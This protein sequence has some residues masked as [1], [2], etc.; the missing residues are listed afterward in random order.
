M[1][2]QTENIPEGK[3]L[4]CIIPM[5]VSK[6]RLDAIDRLAY[7]NLDTTM[8]QDIGFLVV[9]DG[10]APEDAAR[11]RARCAELGLGYVRVDSELR[12]F[13][14]GRCRNV[15]AMYARSTYIL[16]QDVDLMPWPGFYQG[17]LVEIV[18]QGLD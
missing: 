4:T 11:V 5:R 7:F 13:S 10:S 8:P 15:G 2:V 18:I 1:R 12:E 14:V 17:L 6:D 3:T 9:D 16:M